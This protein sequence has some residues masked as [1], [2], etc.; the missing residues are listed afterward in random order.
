MH[1]LRELNNVFYSPKKGGTYPYLFH[2]DV[3]HLRARTG[4]FGP[5]LVYCNWIGYYVNLRTSVS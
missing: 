1:E 4:I 5:Q 2:H 3:H